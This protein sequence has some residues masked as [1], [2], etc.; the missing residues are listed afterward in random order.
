MDKGAPDYFSV[1]SFGE[2]NS[3]S[4]TLFMGKAAFNIVLYVTLDFQGNL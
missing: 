2:R 4:K 1:D 3:E